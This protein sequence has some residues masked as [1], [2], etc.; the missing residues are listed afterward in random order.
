M[1][2]RILVIYTSMGAI[3]YGGMMIFY[4]L[5]DLVKYIGEISQFLKVE[6]LHMLL[7]WVTF[8]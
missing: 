5:C 8:D 7:A 1:I 6:K 4:L 2:S 3:K